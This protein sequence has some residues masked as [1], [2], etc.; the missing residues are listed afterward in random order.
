MTTQTAEQEQTQGHDGRRRIIQGVVKSTKMKKTITVAWQRQVRHPK[1][2]KYMQRYTNL[3]AHD[4]QEQAK[5]GDLVE[6]METRPISKLK[7]WR[8]V[9]IVRQATMTK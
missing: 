9:R 6:V 4:E 2:G 1:F 8:L 7:R 3:H 5:V